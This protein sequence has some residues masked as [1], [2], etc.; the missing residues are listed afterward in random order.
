MGIL[1]RVIRNL[2]IRL[3][4]NEKFIRYLRKSGVRIGKG[5]SIAKDV[6]FGTEP[7]LIT[8]GDDVRITSGVKFF[9]HDGGFWVLRKSGKVNP[10]AEVFGRITIG[11]NVNIGWGSII[12]PG[13]EIGDDVVIGCGSIVTKNIPSN[14]VA[15]GVPAKIIEDID[16]YAQKNSERIV[17]TKS[18]TGEKKRE[19]LQKNYAEAESNGL[20]RGN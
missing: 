16:E 6:T 11:N 2:R 19:F 13:V 15:A 3:Y 4:D 17:L 10:D 18:M 20:E 9:T 1:A 14:S 7:Y 5:C 8:I 12:M